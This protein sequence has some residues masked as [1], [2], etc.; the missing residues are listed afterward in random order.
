MNTQANKRVNNSSKALS[1]RV[2]WPAW[3]SQ[4]VHLLEVRAELRGFWG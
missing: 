3:Y 1:S 2:Q 4:W